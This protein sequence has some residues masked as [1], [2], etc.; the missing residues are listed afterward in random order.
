M[1]RDGP[2]ILPIAMPFL[3]VALIM[4]H[5]R[6][7]R[8]LRRGRLGIAPSFLGLLVAL[9]VAV[10]PGPSL[11]PLAWAALGFMAASALTFGTWRA[12]ATVLRHDTGTER[13][14]A[15][16]SAIAG[17]VLAEAFLI[18]TPARGSLGAQTGPV[19]DMLLLF[20]PRMVVARP[21]AR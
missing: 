6:R 12:Q 16:Q 21:V 13:I 11:D 20:V 9:A 14:M 5:E 17:A 18:C 4:V 10:M 15:G 2:A 8:P 3:A 7:E 19:T 1:A